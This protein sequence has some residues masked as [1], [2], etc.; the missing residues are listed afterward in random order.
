M[1]MVVAGKKVKLAIPE[2]ALYRLHEALDRAGF[3]QSEIQM[4]TEM[5]LLLMQ[6]KQVLRGRTKEIKPVPS[7]PA[8]LQP[9]VPDIFCR[10]QRFRQSSEVL[11]ERVRSRGIEILVRDTSVF[12]DVDESALS[13]GDDVCFIRLSANDLHCPARRTYAPQILN[14]DMLKEWSKRSLSGWEVSFCQPTDVLRIALLDNI[15]SLIQR[16]IRIAM[17]PV[18]IDG[19]REI[20]QMQFMEQRLSIVPVPAGKTAVFPQHFPVLFRLTR[21]ESE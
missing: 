18:I 16:P 6:I 3:T 12:D 2:S 17:S 13:D 9:Y 1:E 15:R 5:P 7:D 8:L 11:A 10:V 20:F 19:N 4:L 21:T 14:A